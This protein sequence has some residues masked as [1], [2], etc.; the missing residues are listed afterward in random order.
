MSLLERPDRLE[1]IGGESMTVL[2]VMFCSW[3]SWPIWT[4]VGFL[5]FAWVMERRGL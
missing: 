5:G 1:S 3:V 2:E 4:A